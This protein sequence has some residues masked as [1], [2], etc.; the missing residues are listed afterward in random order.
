[1]ISFICFTSFVRSIIELAPTQFTSDSSRGN[2][3]SSSK[4][5]PKSSKRRFFGSRRKK[6]QEDD[7]TQSVKDSIH[8]E[9]E[10]PETA[11]VTQSEAKSTR[12]R[13]LFRR[14]KDSDT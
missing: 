4:S 14:R 12:R 10:F 13:S 11:S 2:H 6:T 5:P 1:M 7:D 9:A 3:K 8:T